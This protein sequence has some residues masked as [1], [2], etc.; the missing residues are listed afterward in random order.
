VG[1]LRAFVETDAFEGFGFYLVDITRATTPGFQKP[2]WGC[3]IS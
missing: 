1:L 3:S 2:D